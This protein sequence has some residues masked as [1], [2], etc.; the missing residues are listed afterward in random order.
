LS[1]VI[2]VVGEA[3]N[4]LEAISQTESLRPDVVLLDLE[5]PVMDGFEA[6]KQIKA[7]MPACRLVAFSIHSY[8]QARQKA[9]QA[10][11]DGFLEKGAPLDSILQALLSAHVL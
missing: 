3:S 10:G 5:M 11:M 9:V 1:G 4:G 7:R 6:A 2:E 8:P